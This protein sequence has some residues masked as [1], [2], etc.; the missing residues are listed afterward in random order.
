MKAWL[1]EKVDVRAFLAEDV[2]VPRWILWGLII[3]TFLRVVL[4]LTT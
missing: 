4:E 2:S 3:T 1:N